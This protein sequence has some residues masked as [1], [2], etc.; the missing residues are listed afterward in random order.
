MGVNNLAHFDLSNLIEKQNCLQGNSINESNH[1]ND[2]S[3]INCRSFPNREPMC[4]A[5]DR[6]PQRRAT[7]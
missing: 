2:C 3:R 5:L 7:T 4:A 1:M 6:E